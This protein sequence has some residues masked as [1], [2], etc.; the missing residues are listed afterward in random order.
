MARWLPLFALVWLHP[1]QGVEPEVYA[2]AVRLIETLYLYPDRVTPEALLAAAGHR[3]MDEI[4]WLKVET[5]GGVVRVLHGSGAPVGAVTVDAWERLPGALR[6]L[7]QLVTASGYPTDGVDVRLEILQGLTDGLDRYSRVLHGEGKERFGVRLAGEYEGVGATLDDDDG[8]LVVTEVLPDSPASRAGLWAR[9]QVLRID[10]RSTVGMP[11]GEAQRLVRGEVGTLVV[12]SVLREG[13]PIDLAMTRAV[14]TEPN[15]T[16]RVLEDGVGYVHISHVSQRTVENLQARL[17]KLRVSGALEKGLVIDLRGNTGGSMKEA[18]RSADV[19]LSEGMLLRTEGPDGGRVQNLQAE[20]RA[21][22]GADELDVPIVLVVDERTAS[23]SEILAGALIE[24]E[25]AAIVGTRTY[26]KGTVQKIYGLDPDTQL[27]LTVAQYVLAGDRFIADVGIEPDV[28]VG[29]IE[30]DRYGV[31]YRGYDPAV[32]TVPHV[33]ELDRD[34]PR[35]DVPLEIARRALLNT[36][37]PGRPEVLGHLRQVAQEVGAEQEARLTTALAQRQV[38]WSVR[39]ASS[40]LPR[41]RAPVARVHLRAKPDPD[42]SDVVSVQVE[43][44]N[45]ERAPLERVVVELDC[46][47]FAGWDRVVVPVGRIAAG[48][49]G[50]GVVAVPLAPGIDPREDLV[51]VRMRAHGWPELRV[52]EEIVAARSAPLPEV[53]VSARLVPHPGGLHR[54]EITLHNLG[55][56]PVTGVSAAFEIPT[57]LDVELMDAI[58]KIPVIPPRGAER[59]DLT[60]RLGASAPSVLP[61]ELEVDAEKYPR[62]VDWPL[63]LPISGVEVA[64]RAPQI[65]SR[66]SSPLTAPVGRFGLPLVVTDE[67]RLDHVV[68]FANGEKVA[69]APGGGP[70]VELRPEVEVKQGANPILV[71]AEDEHGVRARRWFVVR[72]EPAATVDALE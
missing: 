34:A 59:L 37:G 12:L 55:G 38:D 50:S 18:A 47:S 21:E 33:V 35:V 30:L 23:G 25:R 19:F 28:R 70:H 58:S 22:V 6:S 7:E 42:R 52:G 49:K 65:R 16:H 54:A 56:S 61:L 27:K 67:T 36:S 53:S 48:A 39:T 5:S 11:V 64:L 3:L 24:L 2:N 32:D 46:D 14:V 68:V 26:G 66:S 44:E 29:R 4:D 57:G 10:G 8:R 45:G 31:R 17:A 63:A 1:A 15:V 40:D 41:D 69:W 43:V 13:A 20:M 71:V 9:D 60:M 62:W 51:R 72:G